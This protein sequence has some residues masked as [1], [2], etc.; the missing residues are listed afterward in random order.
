MSARV[1]LILLGGSV[2]A[3]ALHVL[4]GSGLFSLRQVIEGFQAG[5]PGLAS[6]PE[7]IVV[8]SLRLP[9]AVA[10]FVT[11]AALA[12]SGAALQ[13]LFRNP[14]AE[15]YILGI[16]SG[17]AVGGVLSA[18]LGVEAVAGIHGTF[19]MAFA[20]AVLCMSLVL[21]FARSRFGISV[22]TVLIVGVT[23]GT[24]LWA[25]VTLLLTLQG[26][27]ANRILFWLLGSFVGADWNRVSTVGGAFL[28]GFVILRFFAKPLTLFA[29][30]EETASSLGVDVERLKWGVLLTA[31]GV[32][33]A[34]VAAFGIIGFVGLFVPNLARRLTGISLSGSLPGSALL[35]GI[36]V[37]F[38]DLLA[39]RLIPG[40]EINV[41]VLTALMAAPFLLVLA[42]RRSL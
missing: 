17:A 10:A 33:A 23:L 4:V 8:W 14:L 5:P 3:L 11:G 39:Q 29:A 36:A 32:A 22:Q 42:R 19:L 1:F 9:R 41:G 18:L 40:R 31:S 35:G 16:S 30:G 34:A 25:V 7:Q 37:V 15:P 21:A 38:A 12:T 24:F 26:A 6:S 28:L 20:T 13:A 2:A 27:D